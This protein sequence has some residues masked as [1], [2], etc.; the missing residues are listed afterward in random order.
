VNQNPYA[1]LRESGEGEAP[2]EPDCAVARR[3]ARPPRI[4]QG[5]LGEINWHTP[6]LALGGDGSRGWFGSR[7]TSRSTD[8]GSSRQVSISA[9]TSGPSQ[10]LAPRDDPRS[11]PER[12][13]KTAA[14]RARM[15]YSR[16]A[17]LSRLV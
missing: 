14:G 11:R 3:E 7:V 4:V 17:E 2:S 12:S 10:F 5:H 6:G 1:A 15:S 8:Q 9:L 13:I 16:R